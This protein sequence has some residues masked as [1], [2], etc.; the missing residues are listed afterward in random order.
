M[1]VSGLNPLQHYLR[2]GQRE[3]RLASPVGVDPPP[4][5]VPRL[6]P[7][8]NETSRVEAIVTPP[9]GELDQLVRRLPRGAVVVVA[10]DEGLTTPAGSRV[11]NGPQRPGRTAG[12]PGSGPDLIVQLEA[13]RWQGADYFALP[14]TKHWWM[15]HFPELASHLDRRYR[16]VDQDGGTGEMWNLRHPSRWIEMEELVARIAAV[17]DT[18]PSVLV[19][20]SDRDLETIL[21]GCQVFR[22]VSEAP[23]LPYLD[24]TIDIVA[25]GDLSDEALREARRIAAAAVVDVSSDPA[26]V[27]WQAASAAALPPAVSIGLLVGPG[28]PPNDRWLTLFAQDLPGSLEAEVLIV[29]PDPSLP[30]IGSS[31]PLRDVRTV[32]VPAGATELDVLDCAVESARNEE[33]VVVDTRAYPVPESIAS[34]LRVLH[35]SDDVAAVSAVLVDADGR[36]VES[37]RTP[38]D[39]APK[40]VDA[41]ART[42]TRQIPYGSLALAA[43]RKQA[44][45]AGRTAMSA[46]AR[47]PTAAALGEQLR[48]LGSRW[49][50]IPDAIAIVS[51]SILTNGESISP[52]APTSA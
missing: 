43:L 44:Y 2:H 41:A 6:A 35:S 42:L 5:P 9:P 22:P 50:S 26:S 37:V 8:S 36:T 18:L 21:P 24:G 30:G 31:L 1:A 16:P 32:V 40:D 10:S 15:N 33:L 12:K 51:G 4:S 27:V 34:L 13:V 47:E 49:F 48:L 14:R 20:H 25:L 23:P 52:G 19:W 46:A 3:G 7:E 45:V 11:D 38:A 28:G 39:P 17:S 29:G